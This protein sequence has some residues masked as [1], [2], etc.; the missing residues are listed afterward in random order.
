MNDKG[1]YF[2]DTM[3]P[4]ASPRTWK[5][6]GL[7]MP[8]GLKRYLHE[9]WWGVFRRSLTNEERWTYPIEGMLTESEADARVREMGS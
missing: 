5:S 9:P 3:N 7:E 6:A 1:D 2:S 8:E 4:F